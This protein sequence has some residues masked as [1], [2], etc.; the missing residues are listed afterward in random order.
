MGAF[1]LGL[2]LLSL[3]IWLGLLVFWG[4]FWRLD[5]RLEGEEI[6]LVSL[7]KIC[8][9][10]PARNEA[11]LIPMSLRSL[12]LQDYPG[13]FHIFLVDDQSTDG[14]AAFA[15]GVAHAVDKAQQLHIVSGESLPPGWSG[16]LWAVEQGIQKAKTFAPD[17][18]FLT[19]A[20]IEHD[21]SNLRRLVA[22][23]LQED[24]DLASVMVKL[25]CESFWEKFLIP[26]FVFFFQQLYPFRWVNNPKNK[27]AAAAGGSILIRREALEQIGGIQVIRQALIDDCTLAQIVKSGGQGRKGDKLNNATSRKIWLGLSSSTRSLRPY[28]SLQTIW[29]MVARTAYTQLN[30]SPWL[31]LGTVV[32]MTLI[33]LLPPVATIIG[34]LIADWAIAF[35]GLVVWL[36][37]SLA[38]FP[39]IRFYKLSPLL[40]FSLPAIAFLY[41]LMTIDSAFRH[42]QGRGGAWKGR[43]YPG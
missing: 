9:V 40:A 14:T 42:W 13:D 26:A 1:F 27:M 8:A 20:D 37:M 43:V 39:T 32:G 22:K 38:Y 11:E 18:F 12:L 35:S 25:R 15:E 31:L 5:Q 3:V 30:Y 34:V 29:D 19:D 2:I 4:Q 33:Y 10:I 24:L 41:T 28:E 6:P 16:K 36:L 17:Y 21:V 23:A 7:P